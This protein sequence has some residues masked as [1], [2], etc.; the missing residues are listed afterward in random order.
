MPTSSSKPCVAAK[1]PYIRLRCE[2]SV[3]RREHVRDDCHNSARG[4]AEGALLNSAQPQ[5]CCNLIFE[6]PRLSATGWCGSM[7]RQSSNGDA[8]TSQAALPPPRVAN[9][10]HRVASAM[11][12]SMSGA[13]VSACVQVCRS[14]AQTSCLMHFERVATGFLTV[15]TQH[16]VYAR[17]AFKPDVRVQSLLIAA[18]H[19]RAAAAYHSNCDAALPRIYAMVHTA[20]WPVR[21]SARRHHD[22]QTELVALT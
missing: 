4:S 21:L 7:G 1:E 8:T 11:S 2:V 5:S 14:C 10:S 20:R 17:L 12:G 18:S 13:V 3:L 15:L 19:A 9:P 16:S 6:H 22:H